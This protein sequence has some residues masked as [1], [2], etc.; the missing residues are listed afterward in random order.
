[1]AVQLADIGHKL[2]KC[3]VSSDEEGS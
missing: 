1:L 3:V 2:Y